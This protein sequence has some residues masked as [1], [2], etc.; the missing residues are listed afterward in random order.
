MRREGGNVVSL[1]HGS[2]PDRTPGATYRI[3][4]AGGLGDE[5]SERAHDM[6]VSVHRREPEGSFSELTGE[7]ADEAAL[8]GVLD[9]LYTHGARLLSVERLEKDGASLEQ[10]PKRAG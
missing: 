4:V 3:R 1:M 2:D 8:M 5:W 7:L 9:A 10:D 6:T